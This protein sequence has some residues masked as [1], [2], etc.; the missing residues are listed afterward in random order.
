[1]A[2]VDENARLAWT[3]S[4]DWIDAAEA[5]WE[6]E[7]YEEEI[8]SYRHWDIL[9][10]VQAHPRWARIT[11]RS[12]ASLSWDDWAWDRR[13]QEKD[14]E[15]RKQGDTMKKTKKDKMKEDAS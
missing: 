5:M 6:R 4:L 12:G 2:A 13:L 10:E 3:W 11:P 7:V 15:E 8:W 1:M 14:L 9:E